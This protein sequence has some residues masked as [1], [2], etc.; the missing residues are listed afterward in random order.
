MQALL[1]EGDRAGVVTTFYREIVRMPSSELAMIQSLP[2][3]PARVASAH[4]IPRELRASSAYRFDA[5]RFREMHAPTLLLLGG[6]S[7]PFFKAAIDLVHEAL[8][9]SRVT[10]FPGQQ[11]TAMNTAPDLFLREVLGFLVE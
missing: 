11:H 6:D 3:W 9:A 8:P 1:D 5:S 2:N 7:P 4:T 10:V